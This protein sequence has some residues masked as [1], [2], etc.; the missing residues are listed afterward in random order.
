[1]RD[2]GVIPLTRIL[3]CYRI[4]DK[5]GESV[6]ML[7]K[8]KRLEDIVKKIRKANARRIAEEAEAKSTFP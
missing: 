6:E 1:M 3:T 2:P 8:R 4:K 7:A 5:Y